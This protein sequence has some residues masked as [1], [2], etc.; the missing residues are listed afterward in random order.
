M[1]TIEAP[2]ETTF[3]QPP[4]KRGGLSG[5]LLF[6]VTLGVAVLL[7]VISFLSLAALGGDSPGAAFIVPA[8]CLLAWF[9]FFVALLFFAGRAISDRNR[10]GEAGTSI[11]L[12]L[13]LTP[14]I[15]AAL[16]VAVGAQSALG[17]A[18]ILGGADTASE[19]SLED[20]EGLED[21]EGEQASIDDYGSD[22]VLDTLYDAC[23]AGDAESCDD[24]YY[25]API[26]SGYE[27]FAEANGD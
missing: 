8:L 18:S 6:F 3:Q 16:P 2:P 26:G 9:I 11:V 5:A 10:P 24:L 14:V 25:Q 1:A 19:P 22:P 23:E 15:F 17:L 21:F 20:L 13:F 4:K 27:E 7:I 12:A